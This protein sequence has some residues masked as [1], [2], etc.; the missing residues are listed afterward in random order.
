M[1]AHDSVAQTIELEGAEQREAQAYQGRDKP[2]AE[3]DHDTP[4]F[5]CT[6]ALADRR[7]SGGA[8]CVA[9]Q[10]HDLLILDLIEV[11]VKLADRPELLWG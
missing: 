5:T 6:D 3:G 10:V 1:S 8:G 2:I 7:A 9:E 11:L 4:R